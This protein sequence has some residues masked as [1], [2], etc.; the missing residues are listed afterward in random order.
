[1]SMRRP[2]WTWSAIAALFVMAPG[3]RLALADEGAA[4]RFREEVEPVLTEYCY[5]C[6]G[7]GAK[8][9]GVTLDGSP[10]DK[11]FVQDRDLWWRVLK[12]CRSGFMPPAGKPRP[13]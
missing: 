6:H 1:M 5:G 13:S 12:N 2:R 3:G 8:K 4:G 10:T 7:D 9:G 11:A